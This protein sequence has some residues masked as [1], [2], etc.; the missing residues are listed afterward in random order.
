MLNRTFLVGLLI[1]CTVVFGQSV[2]R[3]RPLSDAEITYRNLQF[4]SVHG[5]DAVERQRAAK[6]AE[7]LKS[8]LT[9]QQRTAV[10][11]S[12][13]EHASE[14]V[15]VQAVPPQVAKP[16]VIDEPRP[17]RVERVVVPP[18]EIVPPIEIVAQN[19]VPMAPPQPTPP[20]SPFQPAPTPAPVRPAP[21]VVA[22]SEPQS[23]GARRELTWRQCRQ[24]GLTPDGM[25]D[26]AREL[27]AD[28]SLDAES[29]EA[30]IMSAIVL[31]LV[32]KNP[33]AFG[34]REKIN[35]T[36]IMAFIEKWLP[37]ILDLFS[38]A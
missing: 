38:D 27:L 3:R 7:I 19:A 6:Q 29:S 24:M 26:A 20:P 32:D 15:A 31:R 37:V 10:R 33:T 13:D 11:E 23:L 35:W 14:P 28:G 34:D 30:E 4:L 25:L 8:Y 36:R 2:P 17:A 12:M 16:F 5:V 22:D 9:P 18:T 1:G 21:R